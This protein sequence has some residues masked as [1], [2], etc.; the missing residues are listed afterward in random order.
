MQ[1]KQLAASQGHLPEL[2]DVNGRE[3]ALSQLESPKNLHL[4]NKLR[5]GASAAAA[6]DFDSNNSPITFVKGSGVRGCKNNFSSAL[7]A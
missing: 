2:N 7:N 1:N 6:R 3:N 4:Y 5:A